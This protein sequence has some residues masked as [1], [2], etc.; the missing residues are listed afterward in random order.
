M[1]YVTTSF[2]SVLANNCVVELF[3]MNTRI[4]FGEKTY[5]KHIYTDVPN[6]ADITGYGLAFFALTFIAIFDISFELFNTSTGYKVTLL[7]IG[8]MAFGCTGN[9]LR[10]FYDKDT[11]I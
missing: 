2:A 9:G 5:R 3:S 4:V 10:W 11:I 1:V 7:A 8:L 6:I